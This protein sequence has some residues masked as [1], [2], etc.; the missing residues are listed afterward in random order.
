MEHKFT[1]YR[2]SNYRRSKFA[3]KTRWRRDGEMFQELPMKQVYRQK[4]SKSH[5]KRVSW[6]L[7]KKD[8]VV[9]QSADPLTVSSKWMKE[10]KKNFMTAS[11]LGLGVVRRPKLPRNKEVLWKKNPSNAFTFTKHGNLWR[12][13]QKY[14]KKTTLLLSRSST[15]KSHHLDTDFFCLVDLVKGH[16]WDQ[17]MSEM[18]SKTLIF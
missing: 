13:R 9:P 12:K 6:K 16:I 10:E 4:A 2:Q 7:R 15:S 5:G 11:T 8:E 3:S 17:D 14:S 18:T 1:G